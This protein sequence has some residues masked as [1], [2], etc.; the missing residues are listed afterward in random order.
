[1]ENIDENIIQREIEARRRAVILYKE[2]SKQKNKQAKKVK[3]DYCLDRLD[4]INILK[5]DND[6]TKKII[7]EIKKLDNGISNRTDTM[8]IDF[9]I[10]L[11]NI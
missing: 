5:M 8:K 6:L 2:R 11:L 4:T 3:I 10:Y 9:L 1:M 7:D